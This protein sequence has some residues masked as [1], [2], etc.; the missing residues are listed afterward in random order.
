MTQSQLA[1]RA[2]VTTGTVSRLENGQ[3]A[4]VSAGILIAIANA[5]DVSVAALLP[6]T[7]GAA[8]R[9]A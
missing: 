5:L 4:G 7:A 9:S 6:E 2:G 3:A 8:R 1:E